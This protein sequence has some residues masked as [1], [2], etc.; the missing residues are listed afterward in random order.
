MQVAE[1]L[2]RIHFEVH[3]KTLVQNTFINMLR[4]FED[5]RISRQDFHVNHMIQQVQQMIPSKNEID[6]W[7]FFKR[8][9][10]LRPD[11]PSRMS[12]C[13]LI[14]NSAIVK[15]AKS[16]DSLQ[17]RIA[18][19]IKRFFLDTNFTQDASVRLSQC[20]EVLSLITTLITWTNHLKNG[21]D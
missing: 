9:F 10:S 15:D 21:V 6:I 16:N 3:N 8:Q 2:H 4:I 18:K 14:S 13:N 20:R 7:Q 19:T 11:L 1:R 5:P 12:L 17:R